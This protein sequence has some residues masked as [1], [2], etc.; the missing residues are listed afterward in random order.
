MSISGAKKRVAAPRAKSSVPS[1]DAPLGTIALFNR[2][3]AAVEAAG[4]SSFLKTNGG[5]KR[6]AGTRL[7]PRVTMKSRVRSS[8]EGEPPCC[9]GCHKDPSSGCWWLQ[10]KLFSRA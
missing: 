1:S 2:A 5:P 8:R 4:C 10:P 3:M 9:G 7:H 6:S